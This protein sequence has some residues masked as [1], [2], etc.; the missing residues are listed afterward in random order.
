MR[1]PLPFY[2][3]FLTLILSSLLILGLDNLNLLASL[4]TGVSFLTNPISFGFY[5]FKQNLGN[6]FF[7]LTSARGAAKE[8]KAL[9]EQLGQLLSE[10]SS[11][12]TK[13]SETEAQLDQQNAINP[14]TYHLIAA[15]PVGLDRNL[16]IDK[17][18][19]DGV[20]I[21]QAVIFK[22][23][24]IGQVIKVSEKGASVR[25]STD[26]D[27]KLS[28]FS[29]STSG[30][31]KGVLIGQFG[32]QMLFDKILHEESIEEGNLVY[33]EGLESFLPRG[34]VL[35]KVVEIEEKKTEVFKAAKVV[36]M[37]D[38]GDLDLVFVIGE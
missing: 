3:I 23:S 18:I 25:L 14:R 26:P 19:N 15:R 34:L 8:N 4:K 6:Q 9:Q 7:F 20:K 28:G 38:I 12:R 24:F 21:N 10:N 32:S 36:P 17:G 11:L 37:F 35:G 29:I 13:L 27:S 30:K 16:L 1:Y 22:D 33:S 5:Q 31:A 2:Q